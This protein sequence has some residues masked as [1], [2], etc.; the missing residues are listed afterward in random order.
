LRPKPEEVISPF[1]WLPVTEADKGQ[2]RM[3]SS[4]AINGKDVAGINVA[5]I[6]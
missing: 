6:D 5:D 1:T 4:P 3:K 2:N